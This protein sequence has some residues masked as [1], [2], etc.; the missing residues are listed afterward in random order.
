MALKIVKSNSVAN[1]REQLI[2]LAQRAYA[3]GDL[4]SA[5]SH[6]MSA[7]EQNDKDAEIFV[8]LGVVL[9]QLSKFDK[10]V[11]ALRQGLEL[12]PYHVDGHNALGVVMHRLEWY[13]A[14]EVFF[15]RALELN[16]SHLAAK[17]SLVETMRKVRETGDTLN[18][19]LEY[20]VK[21][22]K[23][24]EPTLSLCMIVKNEERFL[25]DCLRS[26]QGVVDEIVVVDTGSTDSTVA[27]AERFGA[28][29]VNF[30]WIGDFA[31]A[32]NVS[33]EHATSDWILVLDADERLDESSKHRLKPLLRQPDAVGFSLIIENILGEKT[34]E[35]TQLALLLRLF[36]NREDVR[37]EGIVHEQVSP[38]A[39]RTGLK[40]YNCDVKIVHLGYMQECMDERSKNQRNLEL[41]ERQLATEPGNPYVHFQ[42]GQTLKLMG[43]LETAESHYSKALALL[44]ESQAPHNLPYYANLYYNLG[45]LNR[46]F[47][48]FEQA[49]SYLEEGKSFFP[50][51]ADL[52]FT[53][54]LCYL[55]QERWQEAIPH[56]EHCQTLGG[57][58][59]AGGTDP[60]VTSHK[61]LNAIGICYSKQGENGKAVGYL[62]RAIAAHPNPDAELHANLG[63]ILVLENEP[64]K[65]IEHF[66]AAL[67][68]DPKDLRSW[69]NL[70]SLSY[71][72]GQYHESI[73]AWDKALSIN[74]SLSD[75][76]IPKAEA[77]LKLGRL[78]EADAALREALASQPDAR[79]ALLN[80][81]LIYLLQGNLDEARRLWARFGDDS[82]CM[83][84]AALADTLEG[85]SVAT[86]RPKD[87]DLIRTWG[88]ILDLAVAAE[89]SEWI[90]T[91]MD[92]LDVLG[93]LVPGLE[94][95]FGK[96]FYKRQQWQQSLTLY[97]RAQQRNPQDP[98]AYVA[99]GNL[100]QATNNLEDARIMF[101]K[102]RDLDPAATYP[103][104]QLALLGAR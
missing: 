27:I 38:S 10:A 40:T 65:A 52:I 57:V 79:P 91:L 70:A 84:L 92:Q 42:L 73:E 11:I 47:K 66:V 16:P 2:S 101:A 76:L 44:K 56:F 12:D 17:S 71:R 34:V 63:V 61:A 54:G 62:E 9:F 89:R 100:C 86:E 97:L 80:Q 58:V 78:A 22:T 23:P 4:E 104:R 36:K 49:L 102:A 95:E 67:D 85:K 43:N 99:L 15:R 32:R 3:N 19:D 30:P 64:Q 88:A 21:L 35:G 60:A 55:D 39:G 48:K 81:S 74:P 53:V 94:L 14:A 5:A 59:H 50:T 18:P 83:A 20:L 75:A 33:L 87:A 1:N 90:Q 7:L 6:F 41:L 46:R 31:A 96:I 29:V 24:V 103:R 8:Q 26:V 98:E 82:E 93:P 45:D 28:K 77:L 68:R 13:A 69:I 25:E 51:Y 37:Y 72:F